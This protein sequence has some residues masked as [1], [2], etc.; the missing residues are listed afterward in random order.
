MRIQ[1]AKKVHYDSGPNMTP[2]VD[3]VMVILIFLMLTG[4]FGLG[5]H[6][7]ASSLPIRP[8][9]GGPADKPKSA[10]DDVQIDIRVD[11][12]PGQGPGQAAWT[13]RFGDVVTGSPETLRQELEKKFSTYRSTG[14]GVEKLQIILNPNRFVK[15]RSLIT[16]YQAAVAAGE[17]VYGKDAKMKIGF[18]K[19]H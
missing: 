13:A 1:G 19:A 5:E 9:G 17:N 8:Q 4:T 15:W 14:T 12:M 2:L 10:F 3:V 11:A 7:L 18:S 6:Y 16:V